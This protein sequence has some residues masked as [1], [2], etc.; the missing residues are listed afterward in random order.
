MLNWP[1]LSS[2]TEQTNND[3]TKQDRIAN[4]SRKR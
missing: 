1:R 3:K 4:T 2:N